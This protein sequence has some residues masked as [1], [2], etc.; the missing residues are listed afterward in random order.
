MI[1]RVIGAHGRFGQV[2]PL[3]CR[4]GAA[5]LLLGLLVLAAG[6]A[7]SAHEL[8]RTRV[9]IA[10][11]RDGSF[12]LEVSNDPEWL[13]MRLEPFVAEDFPALRAAP[14]TGRLPPA[15]R[16]AWLAALAP[17]FADRIV[18]FVDGHEVRA[19]TTEYRPPAALVSETASPP[20]DP[21]VSQASY[22]LRGRVAPDARVLR[23]FYGIVSDPYPLA[24]Q[25]AD[26]VTSTEW[27]GGQVWS[28]IIDLTG[29]FVP[30]TR[31][32]IAWQ[33]LALGYV[34]ILP[35]GL[36]HILFVIG[37]FLLSA[38][39]RPILLQVTAFTIAHSLTL[40]L[41]MYSL[42]SLPSRIV[43][44]LVALSIAYV[45]V[46]NLLTREIKPW[47]L[48]LVFAFGLLHG[49][50]FAGVLRDLGLPRAQFLTALLSFNLGVEG[51]QLTV[52][53]IAALLTLPLHR[54][55]A[56]HRLIVQPASLLIAGIGLYW[57]V[58]RI[59]T[60]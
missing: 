59:L 57:T 49:L 52:I 53:A 11:A 9:T 31:W 24:V 40:G 21:A 8:E 26:G 41:S 25:R 42:V 56:D 43:E 36:D 20:S 16:D 34:H 7:L 2:W 14:R 18:I 58:A 45:A 17:V 3:S 27:I 55:A 38:R 30:P 51:G 1:A 44:P 37:L 28:G 33:Y 23:W 60:A 32:Q 15:E 39:W 48:G 13:L 35:R 46:E 54:R 50:G 29:Q 12:T 22:R 47:R 6:P 10:F 4:V 19:F 5:G